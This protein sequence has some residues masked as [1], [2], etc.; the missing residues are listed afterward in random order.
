ML[1]TAT[2]QHRAPLL[3]A[4]RRVQRNSRGAYVAHAEHHG[5]AHVQHIPISLEMAGAAARD[6]VP[7][8]GYLLPHES[9]PV[10]PLPCLYPQHFRATLMSDVRD[11]PACTTLA[12]MAATCMA[13]GRPP[14]AD[15]PPYKC[16][17]SDVS[18]SHDSMQPRGTV[19]ARSCWARPALLQHQDAGA[20]GNQLRGDGQAADAAADHHSIVHDVCPSAADV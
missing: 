16:S 9:L 18:S 20:L 15:T 8:Q 5:R 3:S 14:N 11:P 13:A 2:Q 17:E 1:C 12:H 10:N 7:V 4:R 19:E 6:D